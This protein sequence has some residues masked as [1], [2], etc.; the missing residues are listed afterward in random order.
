MVPDDLRL[1]VLQAL[2]E[3]DAGDLAM[4]SLLDP[5]QVPE[6]QVALSNGSV[7]ALVYLV[8]A[9]EA[10]DGVALVVPATGTVQALPLPGLR[11]AGATPVARY[12]EA[13]EERR[14][15]QPGAK[16]AAVARW[17][18]T[19]DDVCEWAWLAAVRHIIRHCATWDLARPVR[20]ALVPLGAL[21]LVPWHAA[22]ARV[23]AQRRYAIQDAVFSYGA[24]ARLLCRSLLRPVADVQ[25]VI[26]SD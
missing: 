24:S 17:Q 7:E 13:Y 3:A 25:A 23:G 6:I 9:S 16:D 20:L 19:L 21:A 10:C 2:A 22:N 4:T 5:P 11:I 26:K 15:A 8:P 12:L 1:R 14:T 18:G